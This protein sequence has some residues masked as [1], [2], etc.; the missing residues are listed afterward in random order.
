[1]ADEP[2]GSVVTVS[3]VV[4]EDGKQ[5]VIP[6]NEWIID[7][8]TGEKMKSNRWVFVGSRFADLND[9]EV[10]L[11]D[12]NGTII[13]L[14]NF[15]DEIVVRDATLMTNRGGGPV[16]NIDP[17]VVPKV[18]TKIRIRITATDE[19]VEAKQME[20]PGNMG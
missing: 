6:A 2:Y 11:A 14:V 18:G 19:K 16:F 13:S 1:M 15:T 5:R 7:Q 12:M 17:K 10:Y 9:K 20:T 3:Y 4:E 8:N